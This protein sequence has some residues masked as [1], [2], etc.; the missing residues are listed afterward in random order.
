M[1]PARLIAPPG[2]TRGRIRTAVCLVAIGCLVILD[3]AVRASGDDLP[4]C[5]PGWTVELVAATPRVLH[6]TAVA[7]A[8]DG[9]VFVCED[10]MDM[11]GPVDQPVNRILCVH[12]DHRVTVFADQVYVAFSMEYIDGKLYVH[13]CPRFSVFVDGGDASAARTDLIATTN[14]APWGSSS[15]G[16]NQINDHIPAG[17][18]LAMDGYLYI[19]VGDKGVH[20]FVGR[21][22]RHLELP[23]GG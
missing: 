22:G 1:R 16:K 11:P 8:P 19:A 21:D 9:R 5:P 6:P 17:F 15:R 18:Q 12:P 10:Y 7:C 20:G 23:L 3:G 2:L 14:P 13:H 4:T